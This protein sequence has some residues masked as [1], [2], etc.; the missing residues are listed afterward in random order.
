MSTSATPLNVEPGA[1]SGSLLRR[2]T[3]RVPHGL[4]YA[5]AALGVA[6]A[7][8]LVQIVLYTQR[9]E[10]RDARAIVERELR[11][12]TLTRG[13]RVVRSLP[14]FR[15]TVT[16]Y[17][18]QTRGLLVLTDRRLIYLGAPPRDVT[19]SSDAPPTFDQ[20]EFRI[21]TMVTIDQSFS[22]LGLARALHIEAPDGDLEVAVPSGQWQKAQLMRSAWEGRH[23]K[24]AGLGVWADRV[25]DARQSLERVLEAYRKEP[26]HHIVRPG[27]AISSIA[28]WYET[29]P[30]SIR[31]L[32]GIEGNKIKVGQRLVI[33]PQR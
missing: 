4:W 25:R 24:L 5:L 32:N 17:F 30:E 15:R 21:D 12:N 8:V 22:A 9:T 2:S 20:R 1:S 19:G 7:I 29:T 13:E 33:K 6:L 11:L 27:D 31:Q 18:R 28:A 10:P 23:V 26:V 16:D 14:V 3:R